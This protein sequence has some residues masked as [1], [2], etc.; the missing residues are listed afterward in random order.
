MVKD[1]ISHQLGGGE[2]NARTIVIGDLMKADKLVLL[3]HLAV[4]SMQ[5]EPS[6]FE[7]FITGAL[8]PVPS[9]SNTIV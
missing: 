8:P 3:Y 7:D 1:L 4:E 9:S 5:V 6:Y 2:E